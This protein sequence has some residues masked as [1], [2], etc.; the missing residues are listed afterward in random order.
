MAD[1]SCPP[2]IIALLFI[3]LTPGARFTRRKMR[4]T[5]HFLLGSWLCIYKRRCHDTLERLY[6]GSTVCK[7]DRVNKEERKR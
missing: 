1:D 4:V 2:R 3:V 6:M 5:K 7:I